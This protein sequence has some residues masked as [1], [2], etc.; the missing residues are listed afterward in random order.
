MRRYEPTTGPGGTG[1][2]DGL[3]RIVA[4]LAGRVDA[5]ERQLH[6]LA[7]EVAGLGRGV[8]ALTMQLTAAPV[9]TADTDTD[10]DA[11]AEEPTRQR[12]W[13]TVADPDT[14]IVW[15][16]EVDQWLTDVILPAGLL[17]PLPSCWTIHPA[18]VVDLLALH[19]EARTAWAH[20][21]PTPVSEWLA[22][23]LP[24]TRT[25]LAAALVECVEQRHHRQQVP[26]I[27]RTRGYDTRP[28]DRDS[29]AAW[30]ATTHGHPTAPEFFGLRPL[31]A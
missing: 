30:W 31:D 2:G 26:G 29:V 20:P 23:W 28:L 3:A 22:R 27:A 15:L 16:A 9:T 5:T 13:A 12:D 6:T 25:R 18:A 1:P 8:A 24:G 7:T 11:E 10:T 19:A 21:A 4:A 14:A 17:A